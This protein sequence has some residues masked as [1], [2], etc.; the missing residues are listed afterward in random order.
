MVD[1][2]TIK[3]PRCDGEGKITRTGIDYGMSSTAYFSG[4]VSCPKCKG[5]GEL[6]EFVETIKWRETMDG[7]RVDWQ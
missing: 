4:D 2:K 3:C 7:D 1:K 6:K 5:S